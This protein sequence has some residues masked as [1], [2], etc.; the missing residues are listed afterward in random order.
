MTLQP[1][2]IA[3]TVDIDDNDLTEDEM[4]NEDDLVEQAEEEL[5][6]KIKLDYT[7]QTPQ[8]RNELVTKIINTTPPKQLTPKYLEILADYIIF[9]MDKEERKEKKILTAN[10]M[11]TVNKRET[12]YEGLCGKLENGEDGIYNM[13]SDLGKNTILTPKDPITD[14][15]IA[16]TPDLKRLREDI[17][18]I[19][20]L[21]KKAR[22]KK[23]FLLKKQIIEM[24]QDQY[25]LRSAHRGTSVCSKTSSTVKSIATTDFYDKIQFDEKNNPINYGP[26]SFFNPDHIEALLCNYSELKQEAYGR[27]EYDL[28]YMMEDLD[29]LV[30]LTLKDEYPLYY[31]LLIYKIDGL[32]NIEIQQKLEQDH[33]IKH[34]IEYISAL[35]R[36]KIP[37]LIA[38]KA[39]EEYL[40]WYY[41]IE[42][43]G[44]WK[45]C[46]RCGEIKLAHNRFFSK[47]KSSKDGW[48]SLCKCCRNAG[49]KKNLQ[50]KAAKE[51]YLGITK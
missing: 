2:L 31:D 19:E 9:A 10:R 18:R 42:V 14:K 3:D 24:R 6:T 32:T 17:A 39:Q 46:T 51:K 37:K 34:S 29:N 47:N 22:G 21:Y 15:D 38:D 30:E 23:K 7:L 28:W 33:G 43:P 20:E 50:K 48:Y 35:W 11:V 27:Y 4:V 45:K 44:K 41:T 40:M 5:D 36:N 8:E 13:M 25:I 49:S 26:I 12:S 1:D 16:E